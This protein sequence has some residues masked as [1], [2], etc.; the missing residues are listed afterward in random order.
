LPLVEP[1][2][3]K[4]DRGDDAGRGR[5][6]KAGKILVPIP[7]RTGR[8]NTVEAGQPQRPAS[9]INEGNHP[10]EILELAQHDLIHE[11]RRRHAEGNDIG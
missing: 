11:Q 8:G 6:R 3:E 4:G 10:A 9:Q 7:G 1:E 5:D 2:K